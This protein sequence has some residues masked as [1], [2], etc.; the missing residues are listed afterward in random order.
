MT[1]RQNPGYVC[2]TEALTT[3]N[4][5]RCHIKDGIQH[6][7]ESSGLRKWYADLLLFR[8]RALAEQSKQDNRRK[9]YME[10]MRLLWEKIYASFGLTPQ[11]LRDRAVQA[12]KD[13]E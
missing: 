2:F 4:Y 13:R 9:A 1:L 5:A 8:E 11:R 7:K 3:V 10:I 6:P 12:I